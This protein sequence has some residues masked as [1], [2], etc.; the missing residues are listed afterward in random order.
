MANTPGDK[1]LASTYLPLAVRAHTERTHQQRRG[2]R[3]KGRPRSWKLPPGFLI[4]DTETTID[5]GQALTFGSAAYYAPDEEGRLHFRQG[6]LFHADDLAERD[7]AGFACLRVEAT[8]HRLDLFSR[9]V[10][11]D[12]VLWPLAGQARAWVVGFNLPFDL[13]RLAVAHGDARGN[14]YG[15]YSLRLWAWHKP[16]G[17]I[18]ENRYR[19]RVHI[20]A[21]D[22]KRAFIGFSRAKDP[23]PDE[24]IPEESPTGER[25]K[26]YSFPGHF[27]DLRTFCFA[28]TND[29]HT[30]DSAC[31]EFGVEGKQQGK[32]THGTITPSYIAYN[33]Q[34]VEATARLCERLLEE[35]RTHPIGLHPTKAYSPASI[36]KAYL[37]AL[38]LKQLRERESRFPRKLTGHAMSAYYGGRTE[39]RIRAVPL[40]V[41]T[42]DF[43]SMYP[44]VNALMGIWPLISA[45][46][47][48]PVEA[49]D[50]VQEFLDTL[51]DEDYFDPETWGELPVLC[52]VAPDGNVLP[53]RAAPTGHGP[54]GRSAATRSAHVR[55][56]G[57]RFPTSAP[58][59][60]SPARHPT[61]FV[62]SGSC[63]A[64]AKTV[65]SLFCYAA[66][67]NSTRS[68]GI[69][70][71]S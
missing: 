43:L 64:A 32:I 28:L 62:R 5:P 57:T 9:R 35:Y 51:T 60:S 34:D 1:P 14:D 55:R 16:D 19:P 45:K 18:G 48:R 27:L 24:L 26:D 47:I 23:D 44:T 63:R 69:R 68:T 15:G 33:L 13:S 53:A 38:G 56:F 8:R 10:F 52:E 71:A 46:Q 42:V 40:P 50:E 17:T 3:G 20:T 25:E 2:G 59:R 37:D 29:A 61:S 41:V 12:Q 70:S 30:L 7:P 66:R 58:P 6:V 36:G 4:L 67:L 21:L 31:K 54:A 39:C 22:S 65:F 11:C 49:T